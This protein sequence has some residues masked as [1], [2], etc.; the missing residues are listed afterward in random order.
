M[1]LFSFRS[2]V[3]ATLLRNPSAVIGALI[4]LLVALMAIL[5]P[6]LAPYDPVSINLADRLSPPS[7]QHWFGADELGRDILSRVMHGARVSLII[8]LVVIA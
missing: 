2:G 8:G 4:I 6:W 5:A 1:S 3:S 7:P